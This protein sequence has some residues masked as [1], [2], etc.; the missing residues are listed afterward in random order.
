MTIV[1]S[2]R[3][4]DAGFSAFKACGYALRLFVMSLPLLLIRC[5]CKQF[6]LSC[7]TCASCVLKAP[8]SPILFR[9]AVAPESER[10]LLICSLNASSF[11]KTWL[12]TRPIS[13]WSKLIQ[14]QRLLGFRLRKTTM[15]ARLVRS[16]FILLLG[17]GWRTNVIT[18]ESAAL[19]FSMCR[20]PVFHL[21]T[22]VRQTP[23]FHDF[24]GNHYIPK[25]VLDVIR[26]SET[27]KSLQ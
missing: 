8:S 9:L 16:R 13:G 18:F 23:E 17:N 3:A 4:T 10:V 14:H 22:A 11:D 1:S 24:S 20:G 26:R 7:S 12:G 27:A 5:C 2:A 6:A 19:E 21:E 15:R 25:V